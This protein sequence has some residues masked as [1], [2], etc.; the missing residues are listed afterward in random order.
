MV[1]VPLALVLSYV[2]AILATTG[3]MQSLASRSLSSAEKNYGVSEVEALAI[4]WGI[5]KFAHYLTATKFTVITDHQALQTLQNKNTDLRGR[6]KRWDLSLQQHD[7][8]I[9]YRPGTKN[10]GPD[11][12]SRYLVSTP[13]GSHEILGNLSSNDFLNAQLND[14]FCQQIRVQDPLPAHYSIESGVL[15]FS[16]EPVLS[17]AL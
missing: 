12:L 14:T 17:Q 9:V 13:N 10:A 6:L 1:L 5:R 2:N 11:A 3:L 7:F 4:V 15:F 16:S 8:K